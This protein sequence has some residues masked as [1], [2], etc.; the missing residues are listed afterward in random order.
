MP[1]WDAV[2]SGARSGPGKPAVRETGPSTLRFLLTAAEYLAGINAAAIYV[3]EPA[4]FGAGS[5]REL[6]CLMQR[7][8]V[9]WIAWA[10]QLEDAQRLADPNLVW[11]LRAD[12]VKSLR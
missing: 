4:R 2:G 9:V 12:G 11:Q 1:L 8:S 7:A 3:L 6:Q 10:R 5:V